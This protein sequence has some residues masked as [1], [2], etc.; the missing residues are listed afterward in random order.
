MNTKR[1][2]IADD[3]P[4]FRDGMRRLVRRAMPQAEI[5]EAD[6]FEQVNAI[7]TEK[8]PD[9]FVLDLRFPG[10][11]L[12]S[13]ILDL[14]CRFPTSSILVVSMSDNSETIEQV[15]ANGAD[16]FVSKAITPARIGDAVAAVLR[17][18]PVVLGPGDTVQADVEHVDAADRLSPRQREVL[19]HIVQGRTN[20]EIAL[21]L[22]ISPFT[23]R[24][25]VS[26]I[27]KL[28]D[29]TT[30]SAAA[31]AAREMGF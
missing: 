1:I 13:S 8:A 15:L 21:E 9:L 28:L 27:L 3:H 4:I 5:I 7:A 14:R 12:T 16:G 19:S 26:T 18:E 22:D 2:I 30:R 25:H 31:A 24:V 17:G 29:V 20:K 10:F 11:E 6:Q 23:V